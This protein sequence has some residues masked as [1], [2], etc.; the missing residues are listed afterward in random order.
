MTNS[1]LTTEN[2]CSEAYGD[3][4]NSTIVDV[5]REVDN[6]PIKLTKIEGLSLRVVSDGL[7]GYFAV[8][9]S[10]NG[11][12]EVYDVECKW[13]ELGKFLKKA[14]IK[15][16]SPKI[17][18]LH[19]E[20][21][22]KYYSEEA[23]RLEKTKVDV[24][25]VADRLN[26]Y[27]GNKAE[28]HL[29]AMHCL[30]SQVTY[31]M[32]RAGGNL[33]SEPIL[34][35]VGKSSSGKTKAA[36]F[37]ASFDID[38]KDER[39]CFNLFGT[40]NG[41]LDG[42]SN[43]HGSTV[44]MDDLSNS[45]LSKQMLKTLLYELGN[46]AAKRRAVGSGGKFDANFL[47]TSETNPFLEVKDMKDGLIGRVLIMKVVKGDLAD[48]GK[49][50]KELKKMSCNRENIALRC[51]LEREIKEIGDDTIMK[52]VDEVRERL[53][54]ELESENSLVHRWTDYMACLEV[55][56]DL[57]SKIGIKFDPN[58]VRK[59]VVKSIKKQIKV[60]G[61]CSKERYAEEVYEEAISRYDKELS[62]EKY[63][64][65]SSKNVNEAFKVVESAYGKLYNQKDIK[66]QLVDDGLLDD[67]KS[68]V[69]KSGKLRVYKFYR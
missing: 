63:L 19:Q 6:E 9:S 27:I 14:R 18:E 23:V 56:A 48:T 32:N 29:L 35:V 54:I 31:I 60:F 47:I 41:I 69:T 10:D 39:R 17:K 49:H 15:A 50:A 44:F 12:S 22:D 13:P 4:T 64:V 8:L 2:M 65:V 46:G 24:N 61:W 62:N 26:T 43:V 30:S 66:M 36:E 25:V 58:N 37:C 1:T 55:T 5:V 11:L 67:I 28:R 52:M 34:A 21:Q 16:L 59:L 20:I 33:K 53:D 42:L 38:L 51:W 68:Y 45:D 7:G 57:L 3:A 40:H